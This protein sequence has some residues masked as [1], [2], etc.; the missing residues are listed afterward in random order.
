VNT[1]NCEIMRGEVSSRKM[2]MGGMSY[3]S[4]GRISRGLQVGAD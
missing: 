2:Y 1:P 3:L 4:S